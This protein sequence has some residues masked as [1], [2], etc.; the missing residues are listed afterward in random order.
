MYKSLLLVDCNLTV[1][2]IY[3][4]TIISITYY[5]IK[6]K[7]PLEYDIFLENIIFNKVQKYK[8]YLIIMPML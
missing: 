4:S 1:T 8:F 6:K 2:N 5:E 3:F 7:N